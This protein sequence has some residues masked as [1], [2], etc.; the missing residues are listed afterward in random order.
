MEGRL[1]EVAVMYRGR[2]V[3]I[4]PRAQ[5]TAAAGVELGVLPLQLQ[6]Q[7]VDTV[8]AKLT[9]LASAQSAEQTVSN[10]PDSEPAK[11]APVGKGA[12]GWV[13]RRR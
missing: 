5:N 6:D 10:V 12:G 9:E 13:I 4:G 1:T 8:E 2:I 11:N 3:E 7:G